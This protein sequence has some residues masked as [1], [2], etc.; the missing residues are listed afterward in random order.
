[1]RKLFKLPSRTHNYIICGI[2]ECISIKLDRRLAKF[3]FS[4]INSENNTVKSMTHFFLGIESSTLAENYRYIMY[5][6]D[7]TVPCWCRNMSEVLTKIRD[8]KQYTVS[9]DNTIQTVKELINI[10]DG[11]MYAPISP[12][13]ASIIVNAICI[14]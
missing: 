5:E 11:V 3:I 6:Y 13:D 4:M 12:K 2:T 8:N 7:I 1:M 14:A 9:E 10:R